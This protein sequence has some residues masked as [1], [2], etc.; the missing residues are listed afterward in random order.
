MSGLGGF[1]GGMIILCYLG[2]LLNFILKRINRM[3]S[4]RKNKKTVNKSLMTIFVK[5]HKYWGFATVVFIILHFSVQYYYYGISSSGMIAAGT[6]IVQMLLGVYGTY[7]FK[8]R[9][10]VWFVLHRVIAVL[11]LVVIFLHVN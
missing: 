5:N 2:T 11:L 9:S 4:M 1:F 3:D 7:I 8:K 10:G 6:M